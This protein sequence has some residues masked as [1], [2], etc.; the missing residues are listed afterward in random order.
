MRA[1]RGRCALPPPEDAPHVSPVFIAAEF[2]R[3]DLRAIDA[4]HGGWCSDRCC[5]EGIGDAVPAGC[6]SPP[7]GLTKRG[8]RAAV[9]PLQGSDAG[10]TGKVSRRAALGGG[11]VRCG[12]GCRRG[13]VVACVE[14]RPPV[15]GC[16]V[17]LAAGGGGAGVVAAADEVGAGL[18]GGVSVGVCLGDGWRGGVCAAGVVAAGRGC[19]RRLVGARPDTQGN[20]DGVTDQVAADA[21]GFLQPPVGPDAGSGWQLPGEDLLTEQGSELL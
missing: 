12:R 7:Q 6:V 11:C 5:G 14:G 3:V 19:R 17:G 20:R 8:G 9:A 4:A 2:R 18:G 13:W 21:V 16:G 1:R 10:K 15:G